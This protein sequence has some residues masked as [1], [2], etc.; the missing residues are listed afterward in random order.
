MDRVYYRSPIC[1]GT[2]RSVT[3]VSETIQA[4]LLQ[5]RMSHPLLRRLRRC[6]A[7]AH[8]DQ[9]RMFNITYW[10]VE[11]HSEVL[12]YVQYLPPF[13]LTGNLVKLL[14]CLMGEVSAPTTSLSQSMQGCL[15][16]RL[17]PM[18][19]ES[20]MKKSCIMGLQSERDE[21]R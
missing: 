16:W 18:L 17:S 5:R 12:Q 20:W 6:I 14:V 7:S 2:C 21:E 4:F 11:T 8:F 19:V 10:S 15:V 9:H 1:D 3:R 13:W